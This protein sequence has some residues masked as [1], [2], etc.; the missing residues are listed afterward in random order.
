MGLWRF[1]CGCFGGAGGAEKRVEPRKGGAPRQ[2]YSGEEWEEH[3]LQSLNR[4]TGVA[5][6][7]SE[8]EEEALNAGGTNTRRHNKNK[9]TN[10]PSALALDSHAAVQEIM[11]RPL[12]SLP[13]GVKS[14]MYVNG[15]TYATSKTRPPGVRVEPYDEL[16]Y[17]QVGH[18]GALGRMCVRLGLDLHVVAAGDRDASGVDRPRGLGDRVYKDRIKGC[19]PTVKAARYYEDFLVRE[20]GVY[21]PG[22]VRKAGLRA[23]VLGSRLS[24]KDQ[25]RAAIPVQ[26]TGVLYLD[27]T[28]HLAEYM[29]DVFHHEFFHIIDVALDK[30]L[31]FSRL[32]EHQR[33]SRGRATTSRVWHDPQWCALNVGGF[34]YGSGGQDCRDEGAWIS[35]DS[36][37]KEHETFTYQTGF[38]NRYSASAHE[39]DRA[40]VFA[41]LMRCPPVLAKNYI[42]DDV[43]QAKAQLLMTRLRTFS[44]DVGDRFWLR[45]TRLCVASSARLGR[46]GEWRKHGQGGRSCWKKPRTN[47]VSWINPVLFTPRA[48]DVLDMEGPGVAHQPVPSLAKGISHQEGAGEE[49]AEVGTEVE[50][51]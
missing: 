21:P 46:D 38:L 40:E 30:V 48:E 32:D 39:E 2:D 12:A 16:V 34:I 22:F 33:E 44:P 31:R 24:Y 36:K 19:A 42:R 51:V 45:V 37:D 26:Q 28:F 41:A 7:S 23:L 10:D 5:E 3:E 9:R 4:D 50:D 8:E 35:Q 43:L 17:C 6:F 1:C 13:W 49:E 11:Q 47:A 18:L 27:P 15:V 25:K 29:H 20:L 14:G